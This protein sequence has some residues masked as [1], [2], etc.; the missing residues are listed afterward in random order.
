MDQL[1]QESAD[2]EQNGRRLAIGHMPNLCEATL[3]HD[4]RCY[5][6]FVGPTFLHE[7]PQ[8]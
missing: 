1:F 6:V 2:D 4:C 7:S 3:D 5:R 8:K